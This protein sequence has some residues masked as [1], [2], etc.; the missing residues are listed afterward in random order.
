[1]HRFCDIQLQKCRGLEIR[2]KGHS[3]SLK[4]IPFDPAPMTSYQRSMVTIGL[5]QT[6]SEINGD[7]S[8]KF[9]N[10]PAPCIL[11]PR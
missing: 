10:F 7:L 4:M 2:V 8:L 6:V 3:R 5:S 11:C 9:Q 1:M